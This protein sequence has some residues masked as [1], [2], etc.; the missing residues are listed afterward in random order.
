M[1][2]SSPGLKMTKVK[3]GGCRVKRSSGCIGSAIARARAKK[4]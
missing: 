2:K 3:N 1:K 4:H